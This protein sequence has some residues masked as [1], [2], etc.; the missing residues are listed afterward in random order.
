MY[1]VYS[2]EMTLDAGILDKAKAALKAQ[3]FNEELTAID[4]KC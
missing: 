1:G 3:N 4:Q 2:R